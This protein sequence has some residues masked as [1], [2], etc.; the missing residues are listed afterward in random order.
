MV[1]I[2][3]KILR[4]NKAMSKKR[5]KKRKN[6]D[7]LYKLLIIA[8]FGLG[9]FVFIETESIPLAFAII[10]L[11]VILIEV[12]KY[13]ARKKKDANLA[14]SGIRDIDR[15]DGFQFEEYLAVLFRKHGYKAKITKSSGD[16]GADLI[17]IKN[18]EKTVVQAK[19]YSQKVG[20]KAI[21]EIVAAKNYYKA[22]KSMVITNNYF[23]AP[24][25]E[26]AE[27]SNVELIDR[28]KL[29]KM[30]SKL[31][32]NGTVVNPVEVK[33]SVAPI[34]EYCKVEMVLRKSKTGNEFYGCVNFP[35]CKNTKS[36]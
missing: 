4:E 7:L 30:L 35:S 23:T 17:L 11:P 16:Y 25:I 34:C 21:Q 19:R 18:G 12:Q 9:I 33:K 8:S 2:F 3:T 36:I 28:K 20:I 1:V 13:V 10:I 26:L 6:D 14:K 27:S 31:N 22:D 29:I 24:A 5:R 15:M 32:P